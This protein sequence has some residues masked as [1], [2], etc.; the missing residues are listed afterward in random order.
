M[1]HERNNH[2][3]GKAL[4]MQIL[5]HYREYGTSLLYS[6]ILAALKTK[7]GCKQLYTIAC[8][9]YSHV[10]FLIKVGYLTIVFAW[11]LSYSVEGYTIYT[12]EFTI[13][14]FNCMTFHTKNA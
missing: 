10:N 6:E 1:R 2:E 14:V 7:Y 9:I 5:L 3:V 4:C 13:L 12:H 11:C 8:K